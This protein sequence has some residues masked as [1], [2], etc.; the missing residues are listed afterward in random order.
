MV[1]LPFSVLRPSCVDIYRIPSVVSRF[2]RD[3]QDTFSSVNI[4]EW[5]SLTLLGILLRS[6]A[7]DGFDVKL[8]PYDQRGANTMNNV[9]SLLLI[10]LISQPGKPRFKEDAAEMAFSLPHRPLQHRF[11]ATLRTAR[12]GVDEGWG[13]QGSFVT[14][15]G[16]R[17]VDVPALLRQ[18]TK[19]PP[20]IGHITDLVDDFNIPKI[21]ALGAGAY[22]LNAHCRKRASADSRDLPSV[23]WAIAG[24]STK[25]S[26]ASHPSWSLS[27]SMVP[28][29]VEDASRTNPNQTMQC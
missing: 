12:L 29:S 13:T 16:V 28:I 4:L 9:T 2:S 17:I 27:G 11:P 18:G 20:K 19:S 26:E 25:E 7:L 6:L 3:S 14:P 21:V 24:A 22:K 8:C 23:S 1:L 5:Q 10:K 15:T